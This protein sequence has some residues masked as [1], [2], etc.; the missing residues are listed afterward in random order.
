MDFVY[1]LI[2]ED[3]WEDMVI[4]LSEE[5]AVNESKKH[6]Y[7]RVEIFGKNKKSGG[8]IST[9]N[10]YKNGDFIENS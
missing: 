5:E 2:Y 8:Y 6:P 1:V 3:E 4:L 9:Y 7:A 10:Y